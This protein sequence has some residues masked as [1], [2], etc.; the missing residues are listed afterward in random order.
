ML[1]YILMHRVRALVVVLICPRMSYCICSENWTK[2]CEA[3]SV[4][5]FQ[6]FFCLLCVTFF[7]RHQEIQEMEKLWCNFFFFFRLPGLPLW[8]WDQKHPPK[9]WWIYCLKENCMGRILL[10]L[11]VINNFWVSLKCSQG[12]VSLSHVLSWKN[13]S[14]FQK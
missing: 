12:K 3:V 13:R 2:T 5:S 4:F 9:S 1:W 14:L 10:W 7:M 6:V 11:H 8:V